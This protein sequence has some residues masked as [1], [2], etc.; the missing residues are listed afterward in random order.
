LSFGRNGQR[1]DEA[2]HQLARDGLAA[3]EVLQLVVGVGQA[4]AAHHGL[5]RLG[6]HFPGGVQVGGQ[7]GA[8]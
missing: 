1:G 3:R 2:L 8:R 4:V 5:H 7:R 6:Q